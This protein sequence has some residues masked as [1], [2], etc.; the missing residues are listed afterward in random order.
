MEARTEGRRGRGRPRKAYMDKIEDI[1]RKTGKGVGEIKR[2]AK[3]TGGSRQRHS[4]RCK[5]E[6]N[7]EE[8]NEEATKTIEQLSKFSQ[9]CLSVYCLFLHL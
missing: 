4:R 7:E 1:A 2:M 3:N 9:I 5:A 8:E 6:G